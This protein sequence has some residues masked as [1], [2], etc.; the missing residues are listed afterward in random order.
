M[1]V[2]R[3]PQG[4]LI[5]VTTTAQ[6]VDKTVT[7]EGIDVN[8]EFVS[9]TL[10]TTS[11]PWSSMTTVNSFETVTNVSKNGT[12][13][14]AALEL[15]DASANTLLDLNASED[16]RQ[17][18]QIEFLNDPQQVEQIAYRFYQKPRALSRDNDPVQVPDEF[19]DCLVYRALLALQGYNRATG[20]EVEHWTKQQET[21]EF[22]LKST[23][24]QT[25]TLGGR[26]KYVNYISR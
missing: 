4:S 6:T 3:Q 17:Y 10:T 5:T 26:P 25:R 19:A 20:A 2:K 15:A 13:W 12:G 7:I 14:T 11:A 22:N 16:G 23:Y 9:E 24:T 21:L 1:P 18:R 8:G